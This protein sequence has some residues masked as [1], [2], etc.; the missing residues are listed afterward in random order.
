M[1][2]I[3]KLRLTCKC[4][5]VFDAEVVIEAP[6]DVK[7]EIETLLQALRNKDELIER[8]RTQILE[9]EIN[10]RMMEY[11]QL[12]AKQIFVDGRLET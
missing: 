7:A 2:K 1:M 3:S 11:Q 6:I 9:F 4:S 8:Q 12:Q 10:Q 5:H